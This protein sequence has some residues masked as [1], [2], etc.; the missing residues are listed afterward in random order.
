MSSS[1]TT[2]SGLWPG[3]VSSKGT[4]TVYRHEIAPL[5]DLR[6][7]AIYGFFRD[8]LKWYTR[9]VQGFNVFIGDSHHVAW[10][11]HAS[12]GNSMED[13]NRA[14]ARFFVGNMNEMDRAHGVV[15]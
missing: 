9:L 3:R 2:D 5:N 4:S 10:K 1:V 12:H 13:S 15:P 14:L 7:L 8:V 6:P 11:S